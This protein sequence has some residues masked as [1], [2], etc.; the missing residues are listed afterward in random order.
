M[1]FSPCSPAPLERQRAMAAARAS[2]GGDHLAPDDSASQVSWS[3]VVDEQ[4]NVE[5]A[6]LVPMQFP[7]PKA[8]PPGFRHQGEPAPGYTAQG[9]D[10]PKSRVSS[11]S[12]SA[13]LPPAG[14]LLFH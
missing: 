14:G 5:P 3:V 4:R 6:Q 12:G 7:E 9:Q 1:S 10:H 8:P 11:S 13:P 2:A